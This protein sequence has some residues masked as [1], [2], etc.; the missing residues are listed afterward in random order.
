MSRGT[1]IA[2]NSIEQVQKGENPKPIYITRGGQKKRGNFFRLFFCTQ[3]VFFLEW[4]KKKEHSI[5]SLSRGNEEEE[6]EE[7]E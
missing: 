2:G 5:H 7:E 4:E 1:R 6:E 3:N